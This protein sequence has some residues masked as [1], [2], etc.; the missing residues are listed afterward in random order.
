MLDD[1][2]V[3]GDVMEDED[4]DKGEDW[5]Y[6]QTYLL[7]SLYEGCRDPSSYWNYYVRPPQIYGRD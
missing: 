2:D 5:M 6:V 1:E 7:L 3:D 4:D